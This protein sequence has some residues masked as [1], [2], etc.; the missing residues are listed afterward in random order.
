MRILTSDYDPNVKQNKVGI[1]DLIQ[2][3]YNTLFTDEG[4]TSRLQNILEIDIHDAYIF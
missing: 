2:K 1:C 3:S 4:G